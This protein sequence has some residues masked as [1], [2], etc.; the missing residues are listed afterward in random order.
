MKKK[1]IYCLF[2]LLILLAVIPSLC[3]AV[4][5]TN[6]KISNE[7]NKRGKVTF[8]SYVDGAGNVTFAEDKGYASVR[9]TYTS[10]NNVSK[11]EYLDENGELVNN[12]FGYAIRNVVYT[13]RRNIKEEEFLDKDGNPA[14]ISKKMSKS[15]CT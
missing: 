2:A 15:S 14:C 3:F 8:R 9:Y 6:L 10:Y 1:N 11:E 12:S 7:Y 13:G 4:E 5:S